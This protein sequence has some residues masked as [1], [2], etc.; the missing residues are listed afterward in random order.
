MGKYCL[1]LVFTGH[2]DHGKSTL[3]GRLLFETG[4]LPKEKLAEVRIASHESGEELD[5]AFL[6]DQ[7]KEE[8]LERMTLD[9]AQI[10]L[11]TAKR[12]YVIIDA[13]GHL[14]LIRNMLTAASQ[15]EAAI[16]VVDVCSGIMEQTTRHAS[17]ISLLGLKQL[18]V[19][20]NKMD[21]V[22]YEEQA[23][24][25]G[26]AKIAEYL[27]KLGLNPIAVIPVS[28]R[29]GVNITRKAPQ[30]RWYKGPSLLDALRSL[31][32]KETDNRKPLR[33]PVQD[34]YALGNEKIVVGRIAS[35]ELK[36]GKK[37][38]LLPDLKEGRIAAIKVF[39]RSR[40]KAQAAESIGVILGGEP[41]VKRGDLIAD[42]ASRP[43]LREHLR[44]E[45]I[46]L[47]D[48]PLEPGK[49]A[50]FRCATQ[51]V[52]CVIE[53]REKRIDSST[54]EIIEQ[55]APQL[56]K[57]ELGMVE[58]KTDRAVVIEKF[59]FIE[60]LGRFTLEDGSLLKAAGIII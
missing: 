42:I 33:M 5:L 9:T 10:F 49:K 17:I 11:R 59:E 40:K 12:D 15:A 13:P 4:S 30:L 45:I 58:L 19:V 7:F 27:K 3:I 56:K 34:I 22:N 38:I 35:G 16:L 29:S 51:E 39:G 50:C 26:K 6:T 1:K 2:V 21:L 60:G 52:M 14:A 23:F 41:A 28:A 20:L 47:C 32:P 8:R 43:P 53:R 54:L 48:E 24:E 57:N 36:Q 37:I 18:I 55:N 31:R 44:P 25:A 46:W